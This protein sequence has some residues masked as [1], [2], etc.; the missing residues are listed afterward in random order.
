MTEKL[1]LSPQSIIECLNTHYGIAVTS[2]I[3]LPLGADMRA[4]VFKAETGSGPA[5]FIKLKQG[6]HYDM[7]VTLL[8]L[9]QASGIQQIIPPVKTIDGE[10]TRHINNF[11]LTV[12]P[13]V[14]GQNGFCYNL[15]DDQWVTLGMVLRQVH[16]FE[17]PPSLKNRIRKENY[18][19]K[20]REAVRTLNSHIEK[21][22][23]GD[24]A[25]LKLQTFMREHR[26]EIHRLVNRAEALSQKVQ[27][28]SPEFVLCHSDIHG[29]NVLIDG[30]GTFYI[31]D[32]DE[33]IMAPKERDLMFIGG[34]VANVWNNQ[35][36]EEFFY[37]GYGKVDINRVILAYYRHE[38]IVEDIAEYAQA[39]LLTTTGG[40]KRPEMYQQFRSMFDPNGVVDIAFNTDERDRA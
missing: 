19:P 21:D 40:E 17:V 32:W 20:W 6:H 22:V 24:E 30:N 29:G 34:G 27:E 13:F 25:A 3:L 8:A 1:S 7:S 37:M 23:T 18:S 39:L 9:L 15:T 10:L 36:E 11:T 31:V 2:L 33:P 35:R 38:R 5:Y 14:E 26:S 4:S 12:Y 28:Q 16:A